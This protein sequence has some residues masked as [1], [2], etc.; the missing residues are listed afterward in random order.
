M[1][2][3]LIQQLHNIVGDAGL[4]CD[5]A[6]TS[7]SAGIWHQENLKAT[8][9]VRPKTTSEVSQ[10]LALCNAHKQ[11][12]VPQGGLTGLV[13]GADTNDKDLVLSLERLSG[14]ESI[15][16]IG[17]TLTVLAGTALEDIQKAADDAG[18]FF[19]LDL[20]ARGS[21]QIGGN[22]ATNAGG[23]RVIRYGMA[24]ALILGSETVLADGTVIS[25]MNTMLKNNAGYDLKHL[26]IGSEGTLGI[27]TRFVLQLFPKPQ[28]ANTA[29]VAF[30]KFD[31]VP[32]LL[33]HI[34]E[35]LG[36]QLSSY[37]V[38]WKDFY[39]LVATAPHCKTPP[40]STEHPFY[41]LIEAQG[42]DQQADLA[43]FEKV[44]SE[45]LENGVI[46]DAVIAQSQ[47]ERDN[48]WALRDSV[49]ECNRFRPIYYFDVSLSIR[50]MES[51]IENVRREISHNFPDGQCFVFGHLGDGN[52]HL[53]VSPGHNDN[54]SHTKIE[55]IIYSPLA[56]IGGSVS[57]E[58][59]VGL[60][61]K[62]YLHLSRSAEEIG[63]M[64]TLKQALDPNNILNPGKVFDLA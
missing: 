46:I 41:A 60:E 43:H 52:L 12:V 25:S 63:L 42:T 15:D 64:K 57:A 8:V 54:N 16:P 39:A 29:M 10:I 31:D 38:M 51:Y 45:A 28:S 18:L 58:H 2:R 37:E 50:H 22:V 1:N 19:P 6:V 49:D 24:R 17:R 4:L 21:C 40:L 44:L 26:F 56:S 27:M 59:G 61:K 23:N 35:A 55:H 47:R 7:R 9:L 20:G 53:A 32:R 5:D 62:P 34:D 33:N 11:P 13:H 14:V 36:G 30:E 3:D 48:L